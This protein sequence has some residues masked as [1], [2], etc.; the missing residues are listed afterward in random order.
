MYLRQ[1][2]IAI[3]TLASLVNISGIGAHPAA[4]ATSSVI[5]TTTTSDK[6]IVSDGGKLPLPPSM[7]SAASNSANNGQP[8][9]GNATIVLQPHDQRFG[10][11]HRSTT[12]TSALFTGNRDRLFS[13]PLRKRRDL[14]ATV[15]RMPG[16][17]WCGRGHRA[18]RYGDL[19]IH[20]AADACC[21]QHDLTCPMSI[22]AGQTK[23]GLHNYMLYTAM[24]CSCDEVFRSCLQM[25]N[26]EY[27]DTVGHVFFNVL[28]TKCFTFKVVKVCQ[29]ST[30]W[31]KCTREQMVRRA[32]WREKMAYES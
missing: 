2:A 20:A 32:V 10:S 28:G 25:A 18:E 13:L 19:G 5:A 6:A 30:W 22:Q 7:H 26:T 17:N 23:A 8:I 9:S 3:F 16:T 27:A 4:S 14:T 1:A 31:G 21:R 15:M 29:E 11:V 12:T 24:H